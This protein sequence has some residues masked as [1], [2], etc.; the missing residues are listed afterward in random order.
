LWKPTLSFDAL[1]CC[2][3]AALLLRIANRLGADGGVP[4]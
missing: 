3:A 2:A 1:V 4:N